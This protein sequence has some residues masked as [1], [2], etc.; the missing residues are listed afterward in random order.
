MNRPSKSH[1][2]FFCTWPLLLSLFPYQSVSG[3]EFGWQIAF[4]DEVTYQSP[5]EACESELIYVMQ[6]RPDLRGLQ[7]PATIR[8]A[9]DY[10]YYCEA[11]YG[12]NYPTG[13]FSFSWANR[14]GSACK[15]NFKYNSTTGTCEPQLTPPP[16]KQA[17][18][19]NT[20]PSNFVGN[21]V[22]FSVGNKYQHEIDYRAIAGNGIIFSR[23]YNSV[24]GRWLNKYSSSLTI[25]Q[26]EIGVNLSDGRQLLF[27]LV[28]DIA[29]PEPGERGVLIKS[30][31]QRAAT[32]PYWQYTSPTNEVLTFN[33]LGKLIR[34]SEIGTPTQNISYSNPRTFVTDDLGNKIEF[35]AD[36]RGQ[37]QS[38][39]TPNL[40][41]TYSY[42]KIGQ[43]ET[44]KEARAS[45]QARVRLYHYEDP[46]NP[47]LLTGI[48]DE[49]GVRY[50]TWAYDDQG[51]AISSEHADGADKVTVA[52]NSDG[53]VS[54]TNELGRVAKY[55]FQTILGVKRITTI[56]GVPSPNC[57][58][59]NSTF[60]YDDRGLLKT[61]TDNK[62]NLT[63]YDYNERGLETSRTEASGTP[64]AR[65]ITTD[66]HADWFLPVTITEPDRITQY[67]YDAQ[68]RQ[69][70]QS[71]TQR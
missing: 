17:G 64:Q 36:M 68:G 66:W 26:D 6:T 57:P 56:D 12:G 27:T 15:E 70:S 13:G 21:P 30:G 37:P 48:T 69:T 9:G 22:N 59:S 61:K 58:N 16:R 44:V 8:W 10:R 47:T 32:S 67:T 4:K 45:G 55:S 53:T 46:R 19:P 14:I 38:L 42:N 34:I 43:L 35:I 60:T 20:C 49:R 41:I 25:R 31:E 51:R 65:T 39:I 7:G 52:Y 23:S 3:E 29:T 40:K 63:T 2:R 24:N 62:G 1:M 33:Y 18:P 50:A 54:V 71:V 28:G 11:I 5:Q